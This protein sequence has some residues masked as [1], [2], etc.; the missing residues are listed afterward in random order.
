VDSVQTPLANW[1]LAE[2]TASLA[3][4]ITQLAALK[5]QEHHQKQQQQQE[6][7]VKEDEEEKQQLTSQNSI[8]QQLL[9]NF[10]RLQQQQQQK[11]QHPSSTVHPHY[12]QLTQPQS[13]P[14]LQQQHQQQR[15]API[16]QKAGI[17]DPVTLQQRRIEQ[18]EIEHKKAQLAH[19]SRSPSLLL[20]KP[21]DTRP[22][23]SNPQQ[24]L[25]HPQE[26]AKGRSTS[27]TLN[28]TPSNQAHA[29]RLSPTC[30]MLV[31]RTN[32]VGMDNDPAKYFS[33]K[34]EETYQEHLKMSAE[35]QKL[36]DKVHQK[37]PTQESTQASANS[38]VVVNHDSKVH[39]SSNHDKK[40][41][42]IAA[43]NGNNHD[44]AIN[45]KKRRSNDDED[46]GNILIGFLQA[47]QHS[48]E[49][50]LREKKPSKTLECPPQSSSN[51]SKSSDS[52]SGDGA[53]GDSSMNQ[54]P[55]PVTDSS[56]SNQPESS[57]EEYECSSDK[58][59]VSSD[60]DKERTHRMH[61]KGPP[62]KRLKMKKRH[63]DRRSGI[64]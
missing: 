34:L 16:A 6:Q 47:L 46:A 35:R 54:D 40:H 42:T 3:P 8:Q 5:M 4:A 24:Q 10:T 62:R 38:A 11:E 57:N 29:P 23:Q 12:G 48:Y 25:E 15:D 37:S 64:I 13:V 17:E 7:K 41:H 2:A 33:K 60:S 58:N 32:Q 36:V 51:D 18:L 20:S 28:K 61:S 52:S 44:N 27:I 22:I 21:S 43:A 53:D 50:A 56:S 31:T 26:A 59:P 19:A 55:A 45:K 39:V 63:D 9:Q 14:L 49:D 1:A 30:E